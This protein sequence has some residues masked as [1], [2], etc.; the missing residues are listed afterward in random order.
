M[1]IFMSVEG[2]YSYYAID[3]TN[4][5]VVYGVEPEYEDSTIVAVD[6]GTFISKIISGDI[7]L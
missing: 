6:F 2:E 7:V 1:P 3:I 4:G 5:N